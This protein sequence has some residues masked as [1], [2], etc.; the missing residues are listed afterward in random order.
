MPVG[1]SPPAR[2]ASARTRY[3]GLYLIVSQGAKTISLN[4]T[5]RWIWELCDGSQTLEQVTAMLEHRVGSPPGALATDVATAV[6]QLTQL[7]VLRVSTDRAGT[8]GDAL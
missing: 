8:C 6:D 7:D 1:C 4:R 2:A 5:A 3:N